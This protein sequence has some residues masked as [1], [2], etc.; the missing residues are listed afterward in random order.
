MTIAKRQQGRLGM[1]CLLL[2]TLSL[3]QST[4]AV[5]TEE[6]DA[7]VPGTKRLRNEHNHLQNSMNE[8]KA[9]AITSST[10]TGGIRRLDDRRIESLNYNS[11]KS[12]NYNPESLDKWV[13]DKGDTTDCQSIIDRWNEHL[14]DNVNSTRMPPC[15]N[16]TVVDDTGTIVDKKPPNNGLVVSGDGTDTG[17]IFHGFRPENDEA[18]QE[19]I[20]RRN[21]VSVGFAVAL[22]PESVPHPFIVTRIVTSVLNEAMDDIDFYVSQRRQLQK[23]EETVREG[24]G[25]LQEP[26]GPLLEAERPFLESQGPLS[27]PQG[28]LY[29]PR[30][31]LH[32]PEGLLYDPEGTTA[33]YDLYYQ[34]TTVR[35]GRRLPEQWWWR[36]DFVYLC[37]WKQSGLPVTNQ[38]LLQSITADL[39]VTLERVISSGIIRLRII[40]EAQEAVLDVSIFEEAVVEGDDDTVEPAEPPDSSF[41]DGTDVVQAERGPTY[42]NPL[43][44]QGWDYRRW[45]GLGIFCGTVVATLL[46]TQVAS[47]RKRRRT[48]KEMWG[49][50]GT[51]EGVDELLRTGWKVKGSNMEI[52]DKAKL[53]YT[54]D[55]SI[56]MGGFE[57]KHEVVGAEITVTQSTTTPDTSKRS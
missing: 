42:P 50:L 6:S 16:G 22:R 38:T 12:L 25:K 5:V 11:S 21:A 29:E 57:Q 44:A 55:D 47:H 56:L 13:P 48:A 26:E 27:E 10:S 2:T 31:Q 14:D 1:M 18:S 20:K 34:L 36:Y 30:A 32:D 35:Y 45:L 46:L 33:S 4:G 52:Y 54:D 37:F 24:K 49:N 53:G 9:K 23:G 40:D 15:R 7:I 41:V 51:E 39:N 8:A 17:P 43:D 28:L 3:V 19:L